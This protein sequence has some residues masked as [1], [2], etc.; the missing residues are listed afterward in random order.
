M[1]GTAFH[2]DR[3]MRRFE[4]MV[5]V[6]TLCWVMVVSTAMTTHSAEPSPEELQRYQTV[7]I[8]SSFDGTQQPI[9]YWAPQDPGSEPRPLL[10]FLHSWSGDYTQNNSA[11]LGE[12]IQRGWLFVHPNF[13]G[14]NDHPE[15]CGSAAARQDIVDSVD[16][17][18]ARY[19]V[20]SKRIYLA[21]SSGGGHMSMLMAG[22]HPDRFSAV[23]AWVGISDLAEWYKFHTPDGQ[24]QNYARMIMKSLGGPPGASEKIDQQYA[25]RSP[26]SRIANV[27]DLRLDLC[28]G[29]HDGRTGSVPFLHTLWAFNQVAQA[30]GGE[31]V[32]AELMDEL[33]ENQGRKDKSQQVHD[34]D[35]ERAIHL[36]RHVG[37]ARVT[38]FEGGHEGL[39]T[40]ACR[41]LEKQSRPTSIGKKEKE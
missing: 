27:G 18:I 39:P 38:I 14:R 13:R 35:F 36:R 1:T 29:V 25:E 4:Q 12:A 2:L 33:W 28:A 30:N 6:F 24:P 7:K 31:P 10:V 5:A 34:P 8:P 23:S 9:R 40:S 32:S 41:W 21:G 26:L 19:P 11:W 20:D 3:N 15:A 22:Y 16:W 37:K 17:M